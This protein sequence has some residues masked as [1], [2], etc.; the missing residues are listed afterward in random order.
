MYID[1]AAI[2]V[3]MQLRGLLKN[4]YCGHNYSCEVQFRTTKTIYK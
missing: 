1:V 2:D 4:L 3:T